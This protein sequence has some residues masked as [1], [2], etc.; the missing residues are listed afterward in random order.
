MHWGFV[1]AS[2]GA[3]FLCALIVGFMIFKTK[4]KYGI[5]AI[6]KRID[7]LGL[8]ERVGTMVEYR[9][10]KSYVAKLQREDAKAK[11]SE[12]NA[13]TMKIKCP[14]KMLIACFAILIA[15][16]LLFTIY[17]KEKQPHV[18]AG[19]LIISIVDELL[20]DSNL[21]EEDKNAIKDIID[22][23]NNKLRD[24]MT[25]EEHDAAI[26]EAK[27]K[28]NSIVN[29]KKEIRETIIENLKDNEITKDLADALESQDPDKIKDAI[30]DLKEKIE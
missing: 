17:A 23:Y 22:E 25:K 26:E 1:V 19:K 21:S 27:D 10:N 13:K 11:I 2:I 6:A 7:K 16:L 18:E 12:L 9:H 30:E 14:K 28:L 15:I 8:E 3:G 24:D 20:E 29:Q 5:E 4:H